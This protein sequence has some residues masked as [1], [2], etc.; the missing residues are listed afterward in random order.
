MGQSCSDSAAVEMVKPATIATF[1]ALLCCSCVHGNSDSDTQPLTP[2]EDISLNTL[3][4]LSS[5]VPP[6][7]GS[8]ELLPFSLYYKNKAKPFPSPQNTKAYQPPPSYPQSSS[9]SSSQASP[10][11]PDLAPS[12]AAQHIR[13]VK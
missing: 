4:G 7:E 9:S 2:V 11:S 8:P 6:S 12:A 10:S 13:K 5:L 3:D 1:L